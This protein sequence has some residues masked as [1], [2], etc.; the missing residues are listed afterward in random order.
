MK[1]TQLLE[2][3]VPAWVK[4][5]DSD[6]KH[7]L[8]SCGF[9]DRTPP[10]PEKVYLKHPKRGHKL[11]ADPH[12]FTMWRFGGFLRPK[13]GNTMF[14]KSE[15]I[16]MGK[17]ALPGEIAKFLIKLAADNP[18]RVVRTFHDYHWA[19]DP[20]RRVIRPDD[21]V[22]LVTELVANVLRNK[23]RWTGSIYK[24]NEEAHD[25]LFFTWEIDPPRDFTPET[26]Q[27]ERKLIRVVKKSA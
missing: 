19:K 21:P 8:R 24:G 6:Y 16:D 27:P 23:R 13:A 12:E 25:E 17:I 18:S 14:S 10:K 26:P 1:V 22:K 15:Q 2:A 5:L 9:E 20:D 11:T 7:L 3:E 4:K